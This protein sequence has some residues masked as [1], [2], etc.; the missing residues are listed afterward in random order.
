MVR[1]R[2]IALLG[3][4][5]VGKSSIAQQFV[6][7][8]FNAEYSTTIENQFVRNLNV[9]G[10]EFQVEL[11]DTMGLT[12]NSNLPDEYF[13]MDGWVLVFSVTARRSLEVVQELYHKIREAGFLTQPI[14]LVG[15]KSDLALQREIST[16]EGKSV[17]DGL[18]VEYIEASA[19][20]NL[21]V[22]EIFSSLV[23]SMERRPEDRRG[24]RA[25]AGGGSASGGGCVLC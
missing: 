16:G 5:A 2:K 24:G 20:D 21:H 17:A 11:F 1:V 7:K 6:Q 9:A 4:P 22:A 15:N 12:E 23:A 25:A 19:R 18:G 14:V 8:T 10:T 13:S 3:F